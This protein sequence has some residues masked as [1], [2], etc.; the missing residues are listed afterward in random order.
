MDK[1]LNLKIGQTCSVM[2][3]YFRAGLS[4]ASKTHG[5]KSRE[6][7]LFPGVVNPREN[8]P[9]AELSLPILSH[10]PLFSFWEV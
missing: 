6:K 7:P 5:V 8:D 2:V 1:L 4:T 9:R 3:L 10:E